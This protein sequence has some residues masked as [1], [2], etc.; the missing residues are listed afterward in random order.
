MV[1]INRATW[2]LSY[3]KG[4]HG[5][6]TPTSPNSPGA[7]AYSWR[8]KTSARLRDMP[9]SIFAKPRSKSKRNKKGHSN[10][11]RAGSAPETTRP[12]T[13]EPKMYRQKRR[14]KPRTPYQKRRMAGEF[15]TSRAFS[16]IHSPAVE[17]YVEFP[18]FFSGYCRRLVCS[19]THGVRC[20]CAHRN[21]GSL[22]EA[23]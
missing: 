2:M 1:L 16:H 13:S 9:D 15:K 7:L 22:P 14:K 12:H 23:V 8:P 5:N 21:T 4:F 11:R 3:V 20:L 19:V 18:S 17:T 10:G 6:L